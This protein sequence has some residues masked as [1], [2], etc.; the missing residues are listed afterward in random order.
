MTH[1]APDQCWHF[2]LHT[3]HGDLWMPVHTANAAL[4][5]STLN[6]SACVTT[7]PQIWSLLTAEWDLWALPRHVPSYWYVGP[8]VIPDCH[9]C[10]PTS[11][12]FLAADVTQGNSTSTPNAFWQF[13]WQSGASLRCYTLYCSLHPIPPTSTPPSCCEAQSSPRHRNRCLPFFFHP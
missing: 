7:H 1:T 5:P 4:L 9:P 3:H 2:S 11:D 13:S 6:T 12:A 8:P 10:S